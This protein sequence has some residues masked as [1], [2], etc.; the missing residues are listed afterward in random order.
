[1]TNR[2]VA[3]KGRGTFRRISEALRAAAPGGVIVVSAGEYVEQVRLDRSVSV[4][5]E[6]G[7][8]SVTLTGVPGEP[9][10][11]AEGL[12]CTL[13]GLVIRAVGDD[14]STPAIGVAPGAGLLLEDC[15]VIGGRIHARGNEGTDQ[16]SDLTGYG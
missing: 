10:V 11:V 8:G 4:I 12:E 3:P 9:A 1:M 16:G 13:R 5:A 6:R 14:G 2:Y 7:H 15:V